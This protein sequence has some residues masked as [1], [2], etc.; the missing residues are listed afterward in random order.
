MSLVTFD[1]DSK[2]MVFID[3]MNVKKSTMSLTSEYFRL[4]FVSLVKELVGNRKLVAAYVFDS[5]DGKIG[6]QFDSLHKKLSYLGFRL[7]VRDSYDVEKDIQKEVDVAMACEMVV[8]ALRNHYDT[9]IVVSGDRDFVPAV[10]Q[11]QMAGKTVEV[12][13]FE[14]NISYTLMRK[15]DYF[16]ELD[17][18]P[19]ITM[20]NP[21]KEELVTDIDSLNRNLNNDTIADNEETNDE[22]LQKVVE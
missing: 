14:D 1:D 20:F 10:E 8:H 18:Y 15:A 4:D 12:A 6:N 19:I 5:Y 16:H 9:A 17:K 7:N 11:I 13:A 3:Y 22:S 21:L 2:V